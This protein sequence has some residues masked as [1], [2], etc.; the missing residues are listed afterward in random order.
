MVCIFLQQEIACWDPDK[1]KNWI[2]F[3]GMKNSIA[4]NR[5]ILTEKTT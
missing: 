1:E 3:L 4:L 5:K 2:T